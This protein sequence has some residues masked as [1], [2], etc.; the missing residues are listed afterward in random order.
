M[1]GLNPAV[2]QPAAA[3]RGRQRSTNKPPAG[4]RKIQI[5]GQYFSLG[6]PGTV[7][8]GLKKRNKGAS[9][10]KAAYRK[11]RVSPARTEPRGEVRGEEEDKSSD[12]KPI[13][14]DEVDPDTGMLKGLSRE[15]MQ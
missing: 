8:R 3:S 14:D 11:D 13:L 12:E 10:K 9:R 4:F 15:E 7:P 6:L 5:R 2:E 1:S